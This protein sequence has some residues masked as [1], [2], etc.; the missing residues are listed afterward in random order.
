MGRNERYYFLHTKFILLIF[1]GCFRLLTRD[2]RQEYLLRNY[3]FVCD[4]LGCKFNHPLDDN[5][6]IMHTE[7]AKAAKNRCY[8][9]S[10]LRGLEQYKLETVMTMLNECHDQL[11]TIRTLKNCRKK[12]I[13][14]VRDDVIHLRI[15]IFKLLTFCVV[16]RKQIP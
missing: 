11:K 7:G 15:T 9:A 4:C 12:H 2:Q 1:S 5:I 16:S 3:G 10:R 14:D 6:K 8:M 13:F